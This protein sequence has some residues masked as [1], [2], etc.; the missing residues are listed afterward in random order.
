[1]NRLCLPPHSCLVH[2]SQTVGRYSTW[3]CAPE[4]LPV[5]SATSSTRFVMW[6]FCF[7]SCCITFPHSDE[8]PFAWLSPGTPQSVREAESPDGGV[9]WGLPQRSTTQSDL[10]NDQES[11][12][13]GCYF[14]SCRVPGRCIECNFSISYAKGTYLNVFIYG[15]ESDPYHTAATLFFSNVSVTCRTLLFPYLTA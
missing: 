2:V 3:R 6:S 5:K 1:M 15:G 9:G 13:A 11:T 12:R 4:S 14:P 8:V 10:S 7:S